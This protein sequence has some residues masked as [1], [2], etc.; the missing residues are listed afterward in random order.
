VFFGALKLFFT[1]KNAIDRKLCR[2][3]HRSCGWV[4]IS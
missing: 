1:S 2:Q 4:A 3:P